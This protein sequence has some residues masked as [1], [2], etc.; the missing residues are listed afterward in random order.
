MLLQQSQ[1]KPYMGT[2]GSHS[3]GTKIHSLQTHLINPNTSNR[4]PP[5][6]LPYSSSQSWLM[7]CLH[8]AQTTTSQDP[9]LSARLKPFFAWRTWHWPVRTVRSLHVRSPH[10]HGGPRG[11]FAGNSSCIS[12]PF[13]FVWVSSA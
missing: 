9:S 12:Q 5:E 6:N 3:H 4:E 13:S 1:T 11:T 2:Q 7:N 10:L 8:W